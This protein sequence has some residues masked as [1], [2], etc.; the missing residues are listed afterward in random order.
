MFGNRPSFFRTFVWGCIVFVVVLQATA[1]NQVCGQDF[2]EIYNSEK[3]KQAQPLSASEAAAGFEVPDG[4]EVKVFASEPDVQNP[5]AMTWDSKGRLWVA[6]N[7]TYAERKQRFDMSLRD[8]VLIFEDDNGDG[9]A[10]KRT[11]FTDQVQMLTSVEVGH[12]GVWLMCPPKLLFI[13]DQDFDDKP[14]GPAVT[15]LDGFEVA[16]QNYHNFANGL[17]WGS[18]GWLY[19]RCG[20]SCPGRIGVP[21]TPDPISVLHWKVGSGDITRGRNILKSYRMARPIRG[22]TIGMNLA[23]GFSST[24][25]MATCGS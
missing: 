23:M 10:D 12:G 13:P 2:P 15:V 22:D 14:D 8:R 20:G 7:F 24:P 5:I 18:D 1:S 25:S 4:F 11:V 19:G 21:G 16:K 3:D 9:V 17:K 6:E